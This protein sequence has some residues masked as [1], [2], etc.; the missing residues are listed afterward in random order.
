MKIRALVSALLIWIVQLAAASPAP[1][2]I[3]GALPPDV[4]K[5]MEGFFKSLNQALNQHDLHQVMNFYAPDATEAI[6]VGGSKMAVP[7]FLGRRRSEIKH[8]AES[9]RPAAGVDLA[10]LQYQPGASPAEYRIRRMVYRS[11]AISGAPTSEIFY[12][13]QRGGAV[14]VISSIVTHSL[15]S[16]APRVVT[17]ARPVNEIPLG[18]D[19]LPTEVELIDGIRLHEVSVMI[20]RIDTVVLRH[21]AGVDPIRLARII[22]EQRK[23]FESQLTDRINQQR[24]AE[25]R[26]AQIAASQDQQRQFAETTRQQED[27]VREQLEASREDAVRKHHLLVGMT[28]DQV[29]RAWGPPLQTNTVNSI[30][31]PGSI[32]YYD[33]RGLDANGNPADAQIRFGGDSVISM[34]NVKAY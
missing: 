6:Q 32:W 7:N 27:D 34:L 24:V 11:G 26:A 16:N 30:A 20:W 28:Q 17:I 29:R 31:G 25:Y 23:I 2:G 8:L 33:G 18:P 22:P 12:V 4:A 1:A 21:V 5:E 14:P 3:W 10:N 9:N 19:G 13:F 15:V